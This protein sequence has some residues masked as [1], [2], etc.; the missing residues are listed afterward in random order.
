VLVL[1][2]SSGCATTSIPTLGVR[3]NQPN[4]EYNDAVKARCKDETPPEG[5]EAYRGCLSFYNIVEWGQDLS[6]A[7]RTRAT[8]NE[9]GV[10]TA[11]V[12][13]LAVVGSLAGLAAFSLA[14]S[15]AAKILPLA[16]GF[17]AGSAAL[18]D[19]KSRAAAYTDAANQ[20]DTALAVAR[21]TVTATTYRGKGAELQEAITRAKNELETKRSEFAMIEERLK[22]AEGEIKALQERLPTQPQPPATPPS[23]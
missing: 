8:L 14:G 18:W 10:I 4:L 12:M 3:P 11:G 21:K 1:V 6:E 22:K 2:F 23:Q 20:I 17:V 19:N 13:G 5:S 9:W 16:G 15:D 7:Y